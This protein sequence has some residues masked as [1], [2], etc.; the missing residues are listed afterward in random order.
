MQG[1]VCLALDLGCTAESPR[2][3]LK[4][5][6]PRPHPDQLHRNLWGCPGQQ[7]LIKR[8]SLPHQN[9]RLGARDAP[10]LWPFGYLP[11]LILADPSGLPQNTVLGLNE[12]V[13]DSG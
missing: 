10:E 4:L 12:Q 13:R 11:G 9:P 2:G 5:P 6:A 1:K 8:P 3:L 7:D